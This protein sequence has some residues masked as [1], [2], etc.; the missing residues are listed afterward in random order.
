MRQ[1]DFS[2]LLP[3]QIFDP[4]TT[5]ALPG[6]GFTRQPFP[7]NII[8]Q[9]RMSAVS[10]FFQDPLP[11]PTRAGVLP[12]GY[13]NDN[14]TGKV[15]YNM[16]DNQRLTGLVTVGRR[17]QSGP[18][19]EVT[20][21]LP[22]PYTNT[23]EVVE[24][25]TVAQL[26]HTWSVTPTMVNQ[27]SFGFN[28]L[29]VPI[30][31]VT[32]PEKPVFGT[33]SGRGEQLLSGSG[34]HWTELTEQLARRRRARLRG[35]EQQLYRAGQLHWVKSKHSLKFGFQHQRLQDNVTTEIRAPCSTPPSTM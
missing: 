3:V 18:Y 27:F 9:E 4:L 8:P 30:T 13:N 20:V 26:K 23:R 29:Y 10:K 25:P 16:T 19:R 24:R 2:E 15:D 35:R 31:N 7:G 12:V 32:A 28:R 14:A 1:G 11:P 33:S 6:G 17:G 22:L 5:Q 34:V 21:P